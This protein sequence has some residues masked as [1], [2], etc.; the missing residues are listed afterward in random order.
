MANFN[1]LQYIKRNPL[2]KEGYEPLDEMDVD[3]AGPL[4]Q[5]IQRFI[6]LMREMDSLKV[7]L[8]KLEKEHEKLLPLIDD[9][10]KHLDTLEN[11]VE[12]V[13]KVGDASVSYQRRGTERT[14]VAYAR[15]LSALYEHLDE[16][17][18]QL[19]DDITKQHTST[20]SVKPTLKIDENEGGSIEASLSK[21]NSRA[22]KIAS[23]MQ[24]V[25]AKM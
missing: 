10:L 2:L 12:K 5:T 14:T 23:A 9:A 16:T 13:I 19:A 20:A 24:K 15:V 11:E 3:P 6:Q 25:T 7:Q 1:F 8:K 21:F 18:K 22:E 17:L 4:G